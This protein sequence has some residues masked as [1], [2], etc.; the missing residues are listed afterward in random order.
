MTP[1][2]RQQLDY[3]KTHRGYPAYVV[4][5]FNLIVLAIEL[6]ALMLLL[7][8]CQK[9][10]SIKP[11]PFNPGDKVQLNGIDPRKSFRPYNC[12]RCPCTIDRAYTIADQRYWYYDIYDLNDSTLTHVA[13]N[14]LKRWK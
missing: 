14:Q 7:S 3:L 5:P 1:E 8:S 10:Y 2:D 12:C 11:S 13:N 9:D 6:L 4:V